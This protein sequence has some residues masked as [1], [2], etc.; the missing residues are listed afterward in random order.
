MLL[1]AGA[2]LRRY[3]QALAR[4]MA[5]SGGQVPRFRRF[6]VSRPGWAGGRMRRAGRAVAE[7]VE[8]TGGRPGLGRQLPEAA[9]QPVGGHRVALDAGHVP[10]VV[11]A[12]SRGRALG[13]P[14]GAVPTQHGD[15]GAVERDRA[16]PACC[17]GR[18][19]DE[20]PAILLQLLADHRGRA[21][22]VD[23]TPAQPGGLAAAQPAQRYQVI[24]RI[25]PVAP[26]SSSGTGG[27]RGHP[28]CYRR[29]DPGPLPLPDPRRG[30]K[31]L[32]PGSA[33]RSELRILFVFDP[34]RSAIL[35]GVGDKVGNWQQWYRQAIPRA[36][37]LLEIYLKER[38]KEEE[39][40]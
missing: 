36:E 34:W 16:L 1:K 29:A 7:V 28:Y 38:A 4:G 2:W 26:G 10:A 37:Q 5:G 11:I 13:F 12:G 39:Q 14:G 23:V 33:G 19:G 35:L 20:V 22:Q 31:E 15:G 25:Q 21:V 8:P 9:G 27:L 6:P 32:R 30:P 18:V 24:G 3:G 17:L 40:G